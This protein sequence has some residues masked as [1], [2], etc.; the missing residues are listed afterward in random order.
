MTKN[1][2]V[3]L[4]SLLLIG[5]ATFAT[6]SFAFKGNTHI[7]VAQEVLND[8][9]D[10][11]K[12]TI[13]PYGE[14]SVIPEVVTALRDHPNEY[15]MG[16]IGPDGFPD[17]I[18]A[19][20]TVHPG[21]YSLGGWRTDDW[22][23]KL[24]NAAGTNRERS[25]VY[26]Y[27]THA[28]TDVFSHSYVNLYAGDAYILSDGIEEEARHMALEGF[29]KEHQPPLVDATGNYIGLPRDVV[30]PA[31]GNNSAAPAAFLRDTL[32]LDHDAA[33]QYRADPISQYLA[34]MHDF[35]EVQG[36]VIA[37]IKD[38]KTDIEA[39]IQQVE[40]ELYDL[41]H[42]T[43]SI[44]GKEVRLWPYYC[45]VDPG[46]CSLIES[47]E[48]LLLPIA[49]E[50]AEAA[51][52]GIQVPMEAWRGQ[53]EE[54]LKQYV[55]T[56][57]KV[58]R[59][60]VTDHTGAA[61]EESVQGHL[62]EWT[63]N[64]AP[65]FAGVPHVVVL[66]GCTAN[67]YVQ[68]VMDGIA[69]AREKISEKLGYLGWLVDPMQKVDELVDAELKPRF[70][71]FAEDIGDRLIGSGSPIMSAARL[72]LKSQGT[73]EGLNNEFAADPSNKGL[74]LIPD[75]ATRVAAEMHLT[76]Y[77]PFPGEYFSKTEYA[78]AYN[79]VIL[80]KLALLPPNE[81]SRL[82]RDVATSKFHVFHTLYNFSEQNPGI[83]LLPLGPSSPLTASGTGLPGDTSP[84]YTGTPLTTNILFDAVASL[85]GSHQWQETA[86]AYPRRI[87]RYFLPQQS[88]LRLQISTRFEVLAG[89]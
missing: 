89:L 14:F 44:W 50:A 1:I 11:G 81:L 7:W 45:F 78:V 15:R 26:G 2:I 59:E 18:G 43:V 63:C 31:N 75:A 71:D 55:I 22:L 4:A 21:R 25:F 20:M 48:H 73:A 79:S 65:V 23:K 35:W 76:A 67:R 39:K 12:V 30:E 34:L 62:Q 52:S 54:A 46:T 5:Q 88:Q 57:D 49:E 9:I 32:I 13:T 37:K 58:A 40:D 85:D 70:K 27:M 61:G 10:N 77:S 80:S 69:V 3:V 36:N 16:S 24:V 68:D 74:L 60:V 38:A 64:W 84:V 66:P 53:V 82:T 6:P 72:A 86:P 47:T 87:Q 33:E 8:V 56:S 83:P 42:I 51:V 17:L 19:Q 41:K 28:A 29:I